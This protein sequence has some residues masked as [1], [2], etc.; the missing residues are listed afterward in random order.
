MGT[1]EISLPCLRVLLDSRH[2][3]C[4]VVTQPDRPV[5]RHQEMHPPAPKVMAEEA[6]V[7][8]LQP[9][10]LRNAEDFAELAAFAPELIVV[11]AYGQVLSM[12][13]IELPTVSCINVHASLLPRH[14]GASC[15]QAA[16]V[17]GDEESGVTIMHVVKKLDAGDVILR[18]RVS[19]GAEE[20]GGELHDR[21]ADLSP[22]V[23][24]EA[25]DALEGGTAEREEQ[26][27]ALS[28]YAP[29]LLRGDGKIDWSA[30]ATEL[31]RRIRAY[32]PWPGTFAMFKDGKGRERRLKV[33]PGTEVV[34]VAGD[35]GLVRME[36]ERLVVCCGEGGLRLSSV[37]PEGGRRMSVAEFVAG[38]GFGDG[39]QLF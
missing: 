31:A 34:E 4:V 32:D 39:G 12:D 2:E 1:G 23:L 38:H 3:V 18:R 10:R 16:I 26:D 19:I 6:G 35:P 11:M 17:D 5:G 28:T 24:M 33:F 7:P 27:A 29:K 30:P 20:T 22:P 15:I 14:R 8:V 37:Q 21:L 13:V 9:E 25:M 36:E